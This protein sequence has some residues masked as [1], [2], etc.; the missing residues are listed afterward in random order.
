[1]RDVPTKTNTRVQP[2]NM[3]DSTPSVSDMLR[4]SR[5]MDAPY[6]GLKRTSSYGSLS[7]G[8]PSLDHLNALLQKKSST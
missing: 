4:D 3:A 6:I 2:E 1:M 7:E 5:E 8:S